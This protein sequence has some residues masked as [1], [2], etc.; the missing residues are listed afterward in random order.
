MLTVRRVLVWFVVVTVA[1]VLGTGVGRAHPDAP[2]EDEPP[3][4]EMV[5]PEEHPADRG[6]EHEDEPPVRSKPDLILSAPESTSPGAQVRLEA[7]LRDGDGRPVEGARIEFVTEVS[8]DGS[9]RGEV[10]L[11]TA[12]IDALG[13]ATAPAELRAAGEARIFAR[14]AGDERLE[15]A[16]AEVGLV[17]VAGGQVYRP[18]V[19][20]DVPYLTVWWLIALVALVWL[21]F[22]VVAVRTFSIARAGEDDEREE[23]PEGDEVT[24]G[25]R[26]FLGRFL[27]PSGLA[28]VVATLGTGLVAL[29]ARSPR[30]HANLGEVA[31]HAEAGHRVPP[32]ARLGQSGELPSLPPL[33]ATKVSF[34]E[35]VLPI[36]R[37]KGGPH[38]HTPKHSP[39]PHGVRL[40]SYAQIMAVPGLVVPGKPADSRLVRVLLDPAVRMPPS[41]PPL[42]EEEI[43]IIASWVAQGAHDS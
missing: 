18:E 41:V 15:P 38:A 13:R 43:Q 32:I 19:G 26:R 10:L 24:A 5:P 25:R 39:P 17:H 12:M 31:D 27:V 23:V 16:T 30:T 40:D 8:W 1:A 29:I 7:V 9:L 4:E 33:L 6:M 14:F 42:P 11:A 35:D 36:L 34:A 22:F 20:I 21:L 28:A 37:A 3:Q 2:H